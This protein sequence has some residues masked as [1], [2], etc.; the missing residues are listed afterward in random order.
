MRERR[1]FET[2]LFVGWCLWELDL[3]TSRVASE[4]TDRVTDRATNLVRCQA[5]ALAMLERLEPL[6][7]SSFEALKQAVAADSRLAALQVLRTVLGRCALFAR[8]GAY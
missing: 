6:V 1:V 7:A 4:G 8:W 2:A 5:D 3:A